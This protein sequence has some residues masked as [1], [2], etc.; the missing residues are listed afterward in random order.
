M[1][2]NYGIVDRHKAQYYQGYARI[3][4]FTHFDAH[5]HTQFETYNEDRD[6]VIARAHDAGIGVINVGSDK[7]MSVAAVELAN[8]YPEGVYATIGLHPT[9]ANE[10]F[11]YAFYKE[12]A[13]NKKVVAI[14]ECGLDYF[15]IEKDG[16]VTAIKKAQE[17]IFLEQMRLSHELQKPLMIHCRNAMPELIMLLKA[18][19]DILVA[20]SVMHF[21]A[22]TPEDAKELLALGFYFTFGGVITFVRD[23][24]ETVRTI[25]KE[26]LLSETDAPFVTPVPH[27]GKRNEPLFVLEVEKKLAELK[28]IPQELLAEQIVQN[29]KTVFGIP[30]N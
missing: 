27:R 6:A 7:Q 5:T 23:Y 26:R 28:K 8:K 16:D 24:D 22:G 4:K 1:N 13:N 30:L 11:D 25:P 3:M 12:L 15:H 18:N 9:D 10:G 14:G 2:L 17:N 19:K 20:N 29:I 21:F